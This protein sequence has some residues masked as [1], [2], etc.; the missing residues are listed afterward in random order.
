[1]L[2]SLFVL[3][4]VAS[5]GLSSCQKTETACAL[6][7]DRLATRADLDIVRLEQSFFAA[8]NEKDLRYLLEKY[9]EV[10]SL[11]LDEESYPNRDSLVQQLLR[12]HGDSSMQALNAAVAS[13]F[14]DISDIKQELEHAFAYLQSYY[15]E[16]KA[17]KVYT[18]V[19]GFGIDLLVEEDI[20]VIGLDYFLPSDHAFQPDLPRYIAS[21]YDRKHLVPM[22]VLALSS[23]YNEVDPA[24][25][26]LLAEMLYYGKAYHFVKSILPC[27]EDQY[28]IGY[29]PEQIKASWDNEDLIWAHF[30]ENELLFQ[31]NPFEIRKYIGEAPATDAISPEAPGRM[32]RWIGWNIVEEYQTKQDLSLRELMQEADAKKMFKD[33]GYRPRGG[34]N[35]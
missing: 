17:P 34:Q 12:I 9:P 30:V 24:D 1:M 28:I 15:P 11:V 10:A 35:N 26:S 6:D 5:F 3:L 7:P 4:F 20:L 14:A 19:S 23:R 16:F 29:T 18:Y 32:G 2:R 8:R 21:R 25:N 27:T 13:E 33:S 22:I 31:T